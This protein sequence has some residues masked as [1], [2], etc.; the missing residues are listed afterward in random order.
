MCPMCTVHLA[1]TY[2][3]PPNPPNPHHILRDHILHPLS[4]PKMIFSFN[5]PHLCLDKIIRIFGDAQYTAVGVVS[6][7]PMALFRNLQ[8]AYGGEGAGVWILPECQN[9]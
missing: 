8:A 6:G 7:S 1:P 2:P 5:L 3:P 9:D 4:A